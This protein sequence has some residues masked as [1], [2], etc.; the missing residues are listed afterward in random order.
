MYVPERIHFLHVIALVAL[1]WPA[2]ALTSGYATIVD[3]GPSSNRVDIVFLGDGYTASEIDTVYPTHI[4]NMLTHMFN[5]G[6]D[7]FPRY[8]NYFNIHK[9]DVISEQS[10]AD[11]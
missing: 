4:D 7:P 11:I 2:I 6:E 8:S 1:A 3:T 5:A 9:V 10:G